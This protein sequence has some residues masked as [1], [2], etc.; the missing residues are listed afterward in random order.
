MG[1]W[2]LELCGEIVVIKAHRIL[3]GSKKPRLETI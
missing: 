3:H 2:G 1:A